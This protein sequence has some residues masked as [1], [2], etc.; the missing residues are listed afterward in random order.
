MV[1][2]DVGDLRALQVLLAVERE[3]GFAAAARSLGVTR[4]AVSRSIAELER[5][6]RVRLARRTTRRV[7]LTEAA[8]AL[9]DR[10]RDPLGSIHEALDAARE[11]DGEQAGTVRVAGTTAFGRDV[12]VPLLIELAKA[13]PAVTF[14]LCMSDR[15]ED[16]VA[17]PIDVTV[18]LGPLPETSLVARTVGTL[19]LVLA[20]APALVRRLGAP[21]S[22]D[23]VLRMPAVAFR[24]PGASRRYPWPLDVRGERQLVTP[25]RVSFESDS[26]D[27]V[28][29][30]IRAGAGVGLVPRHLVERELDAGRLVALLPGLV[31]KGPIVS[32]CYAGRK[33][34]PKRVR[35]VIDHLVRR[36][37]DVCDPARGA[38]AGVSGRGAPRS[39]ADSPRAALSTA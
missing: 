39:N 17:Q 13:H 11:R 3:G 26:V 37:P 25:T 6:L 35:T 4:A 8:L 1:T 14:D 36:L 19:P 22:P 32:V 30:L 12:L 34:V 28:A 5:R 31:G 10:C 23:A 24:V 7:V 38:R 9:V 29:A 27:T 2:I 20:A 18:R 33:L 16:L 21:T 15:V